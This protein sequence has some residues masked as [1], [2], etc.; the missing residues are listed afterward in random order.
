M[1]HK[2][3]FQLP[4]AAHE[5]LQKSFLSLRVDAGAKW[6]SDRD[7]RKEAQSDELGRSGSDPDLAPG[8]FIFRERPMGRSGVPLEI[9]DTHTTPWLVKIGHEMES[10]DSGGKRIEPARRAYS[11]RKSLRSFIAVYSQ[12]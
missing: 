9:A 11:T 2:I 7:Y 1:S 6:G 8:A 10:I 4:S 12:R 5:P 3:R